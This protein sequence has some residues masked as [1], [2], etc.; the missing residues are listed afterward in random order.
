MVVGAG[1]SMEPTAES[2]SGARAGQEV[3]LGL[4]FG[5]GFERFDS[6]SLLLDD[7]LF[8]EVLLPLFLLLLSAAPPP[9]VSAISAA[10]FT[11]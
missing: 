10:G 4:G 3:G 2:L 11:T 9:V 1:S 7:F 8:L 5:L 6:K